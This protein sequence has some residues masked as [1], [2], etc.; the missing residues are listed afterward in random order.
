[1]ASRTDETK[2]AHKDFSHAAFSLGSK[3]SKE[4]ISSID[5]KRYMILSSRGRLSGSST[6]CN[7]D[8]QL[9]PSEQSLLKKCRWKD[10][11]RGGLAQGKEHMQV[12]TKPS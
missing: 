5:V 1:V 6:C 4:A 8:A 9:A 11:D 2:D 7:E 10:G 12:K 3:S